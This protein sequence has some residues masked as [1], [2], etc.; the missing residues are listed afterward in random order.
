MSITPDKNERERIL[1]LV[2]KKRKAIPPQLER[3]LRGQAITEHKT[4][5]RQ[6]SDVSSQF[7]YPTID[8]ADLEPQTIFGM[9][10]IEEDTEIEF[11]TEIVMSSPITQLFLALYRFRQFQ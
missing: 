6:R 1:V 7:N 2:N 9:G 5:E 4:N 11:E 10:Q 8:C 3:R